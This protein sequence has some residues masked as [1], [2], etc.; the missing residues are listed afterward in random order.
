MAEREYI[1]CRGTS[2]NNPPTGY[3]TAPRGYHTTGDIYSQ[4][5]HI[6]CY[7]HNKYGCGGK[8]GVY[9]NRNIPDTYDSPRVVFDNGTIYHNGWALSVI[10]YYGNGEIWKNNQLIAV[11]DGPDAGGAATAVLVFGWAG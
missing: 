1:L 4:H 5:R 8:W 3:Y 10:A 2:L 6:G 7:A 11:Y 9:P